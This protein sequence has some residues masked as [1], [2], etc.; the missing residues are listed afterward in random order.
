MVVIIF[1]LPYDR[2]ACKT[3]IQ[4]LAAYNSQTKKF[5]YGH[6]LYFLKVY[7]KIFLE[8]P[9][10]QNMAIYYWKRGSASYIVREVQS[11]R[12]RERERDGSSETEVVRRK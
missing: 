10:R 3:G 11:V 5:L 2:F 4:S 7:E 12:E 8:T 1:T 6:P 9:S